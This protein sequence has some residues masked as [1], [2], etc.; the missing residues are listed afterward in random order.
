[1][2]LNTFDDLYLSQ[3]RDLYSAEDQLVEAL[4][5]MAEAASHPEL[6]RA[7]Q[8]HL[9]VTEQQRERLGQIFDRLGEDP[10]GETCAAMKG[11]ITEGNKT[12]KEI[13]DPAVGD[14]AL[15]ASAQR[16]EHYEIAAYGTVR[17]FAERLGRTDDLAL[18]EQSLDEEKETD[19]LLTGLAESLI[20]PDAVR[21]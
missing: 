17:T 3:L 20:N 10:E 5:K 19:E 1:M 2:K 15:I 18:L 12:I 16:V 9:A 21:A 13:G 6:R 8:E 11:L 7:F 14:A 4:P